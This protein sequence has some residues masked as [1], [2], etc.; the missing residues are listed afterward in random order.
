MI[1][2]EYLDRDNSCHWDHFYGDDDRRRSCR[3]A[4]NRMTDVMKDSQEKQKG[5]FVRSINY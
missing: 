3:K 2:C 4:I 5:W 1:F